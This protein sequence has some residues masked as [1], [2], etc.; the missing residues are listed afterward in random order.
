MN[1]TEF[2]L[3]GNKKNFFALFF[4]KC[5]EKCTLM[6]LLMKMYVKKYWEVFHAF[7]FE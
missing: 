7:V 5:Q 3:C 1:L 6:L 4:K 2:G